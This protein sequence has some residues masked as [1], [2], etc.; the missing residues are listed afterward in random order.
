M[1]ETQYDAEGLREEAATAIED[2]P[3]TQTDVAE[4]LDVARTSVNRAVNTTTPKFGKLRQRIAEHLQ[5]GRVEKCVTF[6][7]VEGE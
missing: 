7:H 5:G 4:Q 1:K 2:S 6:V 3:Y